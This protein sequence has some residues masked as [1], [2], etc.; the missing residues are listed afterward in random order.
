M[1]SIVRY[2]STGISILLKAKAVG[3]GGSVNSIGWAHRVPLQ[4]PKS[5]GSDDSDRNPTIGL[6]LALEVLV[7]EDFAE[8]SQDVEAKALG[9]QIPD[10]RVVTTQV[11]GRDVFDARIVEELTEGC[12]EPFDV[13]PVRRYEDVEICRRTR[14]AV[15]AES[16]GTED[17]VLDAVLMESTKDGL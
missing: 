10:G 1:S 4:P 13:L 2:R 15:K 5:S 16:Y 9:W 17:R 11:I 12:L 6:L 8:P 7:E 14:E 3:E